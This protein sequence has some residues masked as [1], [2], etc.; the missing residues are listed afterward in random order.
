MSVCDSRNQVRAS[1]EE[2]A[3]EA[4]QYPSSAVRHRE[5]QMSVCDSHNQVRASEEETAI[6]AISIPLKQ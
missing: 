4:I 6:E 1:E 5:S 2:T 3:I